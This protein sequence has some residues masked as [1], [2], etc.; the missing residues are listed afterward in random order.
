MNHK[1]VIKY[2]QHKHDDCIDDMLAAAL[3]GNTNKSSRAASRA[4]ACEQVI[5]IIKEDNDVEGSNSTTKNRSPKK[6]MCG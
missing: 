3:E 6:T 1:D 5:E 4:H 2:L